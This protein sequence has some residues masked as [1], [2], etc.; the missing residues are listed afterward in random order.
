M[1]HIRGKCDLL[2]GKTGKCAD[3]DVDLS[4]EFHF[5]NFLEV[6]SEWRCGLAASDDTS[7]QG[8]VVSRRSNER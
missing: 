4:M 2:H 3:D 1:H 6:I 5:N 8:T 7:L